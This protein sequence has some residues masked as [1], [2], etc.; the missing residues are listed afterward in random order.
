MEYIIRA[1]PLNN[2]WENVNTPYLMSVMQAYNYLLKFYA[3]DPE[4]SRILLVVYENN[5]LEV[6]IF[7]NKRERHSKIHK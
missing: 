2:P 6:W 4:D 7:I 5:S 1:P 3:K